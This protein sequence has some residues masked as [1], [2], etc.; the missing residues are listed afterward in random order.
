MLGMPA[1]NHRDLSGSG[2]PFS[3]L[4]A[5]TT[6]LLLGDF[7]RMRSRYRAEWA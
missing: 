7:V 3:H 4:F 1:F 5:R 6:G 2:A